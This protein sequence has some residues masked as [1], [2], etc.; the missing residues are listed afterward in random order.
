MISALNQ[1]LVQTAVYASAV[2][3]AAMPAVAQAAAD[4]CGGVKVSSALS[5]LCKDS[6]ANPIFALASAGIYF[7]SSLFGLLLVLV[8]VIS[9][10]QYITSAGSS[11]G[12][13]EAKERLKAAVTGLVLFILMFAI[14]Q[15]LLPDSVKLFR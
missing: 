3:A 13:K 8:I 15:L 9:G 1:R 6:Q 12:T 5:G 4:S 14:L 11:D 7:F 2:I 10:I